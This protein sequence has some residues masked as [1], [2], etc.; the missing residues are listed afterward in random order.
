MFLDRTILKC[1]SAVALHRILRSKVK[2][3]F[4]RYGA[5]TS[6]LVLATPILST[7]KVLPPMLSEKHWAYAEAPTGRGADGGA[8]PLMELPLL[9]LYFLES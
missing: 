7:L 9:G 4:A 1:V 6:Q 8:Y 2:V 3:F 5:C